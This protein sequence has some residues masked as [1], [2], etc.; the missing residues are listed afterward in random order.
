MYFLCQFWE[1]SWDL[2]GFQNEPEIVPENSSKFNEF[3]YRFFSQFW[4]SGGHQNHEKKGY[5]AQ[6]ENATAPTRELNS[7]VL[8]HLQ[9]FPKIMLIFHRILN[10]F[11]IALRAPGGPKKPSKTCAKILSKINTFLI[12]FW[13]SKW[14]QKGFKM[15][16]QNVL[17][18]R[19]KNERKNDRKRTS[20][21]LTPSLQKWIK[22]PLN[23]DGF[24]RMPLGAP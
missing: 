9:M 6:G 19:L 11:L 21:P 22:N 23:F 3:L 10:H 1:P 14:C 7:G 20:I 24:S 12:D 15:Q 5:V 4:G 2:Q 17:K 8:G 18:N 16:S 13:V